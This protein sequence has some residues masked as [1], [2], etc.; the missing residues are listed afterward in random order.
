MQGLLSPTLDFV[1]KSLFA[2]PGNKDMLISLLAAVLRPASP[3]RD[4]TVL[5]PELPRS[6]ASLRGL[7]LDVHAVLEDGREV[8]IETQTVLQAGTRERSLYHWSRMFSE[9]LVRGEAFAALVPCAAVFFVARPALP[10]PRLHSTFRVLEIHNH[11]P[12]CEHL[13]VHFVELTKLDDG[14][15]ENDS[16][17]VDWSSFL[18]CR[19]EAEIDR[20]ARRNPMIA[21]ARS[22][23]ERLSA[24]KKARYLA[25]KREEWLL[26]QQ[27]EKAEARRQGVREGLEQGKRKVLLRLLQRRFGE[28]PEWVAMRVGAGSAAELDEWTERILTARG[29]DEMFG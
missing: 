23:L 4:I 17:L 13:E 1:F 3:I 29:L 8:D 14:R 26:T 18:A 11:E 24:D 15:A 2:L 28:L 20:A 5:N 9:Q 7:V 19:D 10:W 12:L 21:K 25:R 27:F 16:E 22:E 6:A